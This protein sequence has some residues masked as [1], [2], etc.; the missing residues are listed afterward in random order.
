MASGFQFLHFKQI[1][2]ERFY[3]L[4]KRSFQFYS[5]Q[6]LLCFLFSVF[7]FIV[8]LFFSKFYLMLTFDYTPLLIRIEQKCG[9]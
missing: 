3:V 6:F 8:L 2:S 4:S 1:H 9:R 5:W 7:C